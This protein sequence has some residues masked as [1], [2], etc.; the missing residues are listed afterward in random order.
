MLRGAQRV[1]LIGRVP[2]FAGCSRRELV[3][4]ARISEEVE[5]RPGKVLI[6]EGERGGE[7][8]ALVE[9]S[10]DVRRKGRKIDTVGGGDFVGEMALVT[11][12]LRNATVTATSPVRALVV[13]K[14]DF[15]RLVASNPLIAF[16]VMHSVAER[17]PPGVSD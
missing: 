16:K 14:A 3:G 2:L 13:R 10:A 17:L 4:I 11:D 8:F 15:R 12:H 7:F 5:F 1:E 9:G 6:R